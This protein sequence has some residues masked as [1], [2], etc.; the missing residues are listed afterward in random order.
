MVA[1]ASG[2][3]GAGDRHRRLDAY[4]PRIVLRLLAATPDAR[5]RTVEATVVFADIS[6]FTRL[7]ERLARRGREGAEELA[8]TIGGCLSA[9]L[10]VAH[11][12]AGELLK[13]GGDA[14]LLLFEGEDHASR[15]CRSALE[16]RRRLRDVGRLRT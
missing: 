9:L 5:F 7:S 6:G 14:L 12:N 8:E 15:A 11:E 1:A 2:V 16:M 13:I 3:L 10:A 4:V